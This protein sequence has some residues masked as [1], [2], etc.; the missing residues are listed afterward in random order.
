MSF[1]FVSPGL[2]RNVRVRSPNALTLRAFWDLLRVIFVRLD[3]ARTILALTNRD[4][5]IWWRCNTPLPFPTDRTAGKGEDGAGLNLSTQLV[6]LI[7]FFNHVRHFIYLL[8]TKFVER[9][10]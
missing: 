6:E 10:Y 3:Y 2:M 4:S 9:D 5:T 8:A 1:F 7:L